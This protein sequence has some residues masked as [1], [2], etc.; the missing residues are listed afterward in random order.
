MPYDERIVTPMR[1]ELVRVGFMEL[2]TAA[3]VDQFMKTAKG[4]NLVVINSVCGCAAGMA[5]PGVSLAVKH[6][7]RPDHLTTVFAGQDLDAVSR[8]REYIGNIPP[9]SPSMALFRDGELV[10]IL[11]RHQIEGRSA[12][13]VAKSLIEAFDKFCVKE[14]A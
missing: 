9:S 3:E 12:E 6:K 11:P 2:R 8:V 10:W 7:N 14:I 5:R 13:L 4:L 1:E